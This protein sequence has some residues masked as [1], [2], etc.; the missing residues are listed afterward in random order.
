M[1]F[2]AGEFLYENKDGVPGVR[3]FDEQFSQILKEFTVLIDKLWA[4]HRTS[5]T[6]GGEDKFYAWGT[7][8]YVVVISGRGFDDLIEI[9]TKHGNVDIFRRED[10]KLSCAINK[11]EKDGHRKGVGVPKAKSPED[12][13]P[14]EEI[15]QRTC[16]ALI[17]YY[18]HPML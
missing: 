6:I 3:D 2:Q 10:G 18:Y 1:Q 15:L 4:E 13:L 17:R 5:P 14:I 12:M 11:E 7:M 9:K 8:E 16:S